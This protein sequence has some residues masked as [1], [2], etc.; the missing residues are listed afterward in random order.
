MKKYKGIPA[1]GGIA[2]GEILVYHH[3]AA[4]EIPVSISPEEVSGQ[5]AQYAAALEKAHSELLGLADALRERSP[6]EAGIFTAQTELLEDEEIAEE[7]RSAI[8]AGRLSAAAAVQR[9]YAQYAA[10]MTELSDEY[11]SARGADLLDVSQRLLGAL[12]YRKGVSLS[13]LARPVILVAHELFPSDTASMRRE[14][15]LAIVTEAGGETS[16]SAILARS[17]GIPAVLGVKDI[18]SLAADGQLCA[19]DGENGCLWLEPDAETLAICKAQKHGFLRRRAMLAENAAGPAVLISG[20]KIDIGLNA[21]SAAPDAAMESCDYV[22]LFRTEFLYMNSADLPGEEAQYQVYRSLIR[23]AGGKMVTI[24]TLDIGGDKTLPYFALPKEDNPF[25]GVR[26]LRLC[27]AHPEI[28]QP[29][30][31]AILRAAVE[32]PVQVMFPMV[33]SLED[34]R[35]GQAAL[36]A[37]AQ[38]LKAEGIPCRTDIPVGVMIEIPSAALIADQLAAEADFASIGTNDLTQYLHAADRMNPEAAPYYQTYSPALFRLLSYV[39]EAFNAAGKPLSVCGELGG[40]PL[41]VPLLAGLGIKKLSM[42]P[43][44]MA[45]AKYIIRHTTLDDAKALA[46]KALHAATQE[47]IRALLQEAQSRIF[48]QS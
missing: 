30:L 47:E 5:L 37:A 23:A 34:L 12:G 17:F 15:V 18:A 42:N 27:L 8:S 46:G 29:Q 14:N 39:S 44:Q 22:G 38:T 36:R 7:I 33:G 11:L 3:E 24:R 1:S 16:H 25:L 20:E 2:V 48:P 26:A 28:L 41:A 35:A 32:G 9:V 21:G 4:E 43:S 10:M 40:D 45:A 13:E 19:V 6:A 31:R